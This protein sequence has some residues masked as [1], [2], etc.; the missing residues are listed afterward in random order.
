MNGNRKTTALNLLVVALLLLAVPLAVGAVEWRNDV[1]SGEYISEPG[2]I[3]DNDTRFVTGYLW[4]KASTD[5]AGGYFEHFNGT[6]VGEGDAIDF[7]DVSLFNDSYNRV[8][9]PSVSS[10]SDSA[11]YTD[12]VVLGFNVNA[13]SLMQWSANRFVVHVDAG[14]NVSVRLRYESNATL[15]GKIVVDLGTFNSTVQ[16]E[17]VYIDT[18]TLMTL[19]TDQPNG[20]FYIRIR[21]GDETTN[22]LAPGDVIKIS[23]AFEHKRGATGLWPMETVA[24]GIGGLFFFFGLALTPYFNPLD[25]AGH[26]IYIPYHLPKHKRRVKGHA[27]Y[28]RTRR[29]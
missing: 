9:I 25:R 12:Y 22:E 26:I 6:N 1:W 27:R 3:Y 29:R 28:N 11:T 4:D 24:A 10:T 16:D 7:Y 13:S 20:H 18:L 19:N 21:S 14:K 2:L 17:T 5:L 23:M 8:M 15:Y